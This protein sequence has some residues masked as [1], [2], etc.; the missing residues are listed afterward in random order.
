MRARGLFNLC[1]FILVIIA[2]YPVTAQQLKVQQTPE[3]INQL[4]TRALSY[5][6]D[7]SAV[8]TIHDITEVSFIAGE[9]E[10]YQ[11]NASNA[12]I[13]F[14]LAIHNDAREDL[15]LELNYP[16]L[17]TVDY[18]LI[19][20]NGRLIKQFR[21]GSAFPFDQRMVK[22][23]HPKFIIPPGVFTCYL[24]I[25]STYNIQFQAKLYN[26]SGLRSENNSELIQQGIYIG[27]CIFIIAYSFFLF[28][29]TRDQIYNY[30]ILHVIA[31]ALITL[32]L[33]GF[34]FQYLWPNYPVINQ[35]EPL[36]FG[37][38]IFTTLFSIRFL[39]LGQV[40]PVWHRILWAALI[41]N[42]PV[43][44]LPF[45]GFK[46]A[47][48]VLVQLVGITGCSLMLIA[49]IIAWLRGYRPARFYVIAFSVFLI[50]V[51]VSILERIGVLPNYYLFIHASQIGS[52]LDIILLSLAI[53]DRYNRITSDKEAADLE[54]LRQT[55]E[56]RQ[57]VELQNERLQTLVEE[58]TK[59]LENSNQALGRRKEELEELHHYN[60]RVFSVIA[61]DLRGGV[62]NLMSAFDQLGENPA[63][64]P[65]E[66][67]RSL[68]KVSRETFYLLENLLTWGRINDGDFMPYSTPMN[69]GL[70]IES[71]L[72][73]IEPLAEN[74]SIQITYENHS[75]H[76]LIIADRNYLGI[77]VRN[78]LNNAVKFTSNQGKIHVACDVSGADWRMIITD[79]GVGMSPEKIDAF[80]N[81]ANVKSSRGTGGETGTGLGLSICREV[82]QLFNGHIQVSPALNSGTTFTVTIPVTTQDN[83][84]PKTSDS[85][86]RKQ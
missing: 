81:S 2:A 45:I 10:G 42:I 15:I 38:G 40:A 48:N 64:Y 50:G 85:Q 60:N 86:R 75:K 39:Q 47:A 16:I 8:K 22:G 70:V 18:Y 83:A 67:L 13:W 63:N 71:A 27:F 54:L 84:S 37:L 4:I 41:V 61:H 80:N 46:I 55:E 44:I 19:A 68:G 57:L 43:F 77:V 3:G 59:A 53:A 1:T 31:T 79:T 11:F 5:H 17:D 52:S 56:N 62:G 29:S 30:Y 51:V 24:R 69:P 33:G 9:K 65:P 14:K 21:T 26:T 23:N 32:H 12:A 34:T 58:R 78:L 25:A 49:G 36:I 35:Y 76:T 20:P 6:V 7:S 82:I 66:L 74:K 72:R 73:R 28:L